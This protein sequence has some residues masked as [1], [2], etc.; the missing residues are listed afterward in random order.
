MKQAVNIR[1]KVST[2]AALAVGI[3]FSFQSSITLAACG[4]DEEWGDR[5]SDLKE[6]VQNHYKSGTISELTREQFCFKVYDNHAQKAHEYEELQ[7]AIA[8][9][10]P[11]EFDR[12][13]IDLRFIFNNGS[14]SK[15]E[16][17]GEEQTIGILGGTG[18]LSDA[19][20]VN[21]ITKH[22]NLEEP[23]FHKM[24]LRDA[25]MI[26]LYSLP[27]PRSGSQYVYSPDWLGRLAGPGLPG[28]VDEGFMSHGY[29]NYYMASNTAHTK[30]QTLIDV[31]NGLQIAA[32]VNLIYWA[33]AGFS[34]PKVPNIAHLPK[35]LLDKIIESDVPQRQKENILILGTKE[36]WNKKLYKGLMEDKGISYKR[37]KTSDEQDN[38][39]EYIDKI[40]QG[41]AT[42]NELENLYNKIFELASTYGTNNVL[43]SCTELPLG[44]KKYIKT[45]KNGVKT[46]SKAG[47]NDIIVYDSEEMFAEIIVDNINDYFYYN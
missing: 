20:L 29:R 34:L 16:M 46:L 19:S 42:E 45:Q 2:S 13:V 43:L 40:K 35:D 17:P 1:L 39:Q 30:R 24:R 31:S 41:T 32:R 44:L 7:Q 10:I 8:D 18:P 37:L 27:P 3:L 6:K 36:A 38:M 15:G 23:E 26:H 22:V 33:S 9:V 11:V 25:F 4:S 21:I 14:L 12:P 28:T 5:F 47:Y